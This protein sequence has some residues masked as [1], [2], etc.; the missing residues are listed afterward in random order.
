MSL[1]CDVKQV[2][3]A[4]AKDWFYLE[5]EDLSLVMERAEKKKNLFLKR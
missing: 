3:Y 2:D 5:N 4:D 1:I